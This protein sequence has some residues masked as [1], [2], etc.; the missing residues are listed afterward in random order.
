[1]MQTGIQRQFHVAFWRPAPEKDQKLEFNARNGPK[2]G[3]ERPK[4]PYAREL[5]KSQPQHI[6]SGPHKWIS[7]LSIIVYSFSVNLGY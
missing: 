6:P 3:V 4:Q 7:A 2:P 1:M 5:L